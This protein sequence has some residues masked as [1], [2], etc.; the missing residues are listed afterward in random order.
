VDQGWVDSKKHIW[1]GRIDKKKGTS[2]AG[3]WEG[4]RKEV[5]SESTNSGRRTLPNKQR[6][7]ITYPKKLTPGPVCK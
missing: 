1:K 4:H 2:N 3:F 7:A 5:D 6:G